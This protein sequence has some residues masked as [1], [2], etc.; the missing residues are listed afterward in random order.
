MGLNRKEQAQ[1]LKQWINAKLEKDRIAAVPDLFTEYFEENKNIVHE[2]YALSRHAFW[3]HFAEVSQSYWY[4]S[5]DYKGRLTAYYNDPT[6][7]K[8]S[9]KIRG[10]GGWESRKVGILKPCRSKDILVNSRGYDRQLPDITDV[11][12]ALASPKNHQQSTTLSSLE[13]SDMSPRRFFVPLQANDA[14]PIRGPDLDMAITSPPSARRRVHSGIPLSYRSP[15]AVELVRTAWSRAL[16]A[17]VSQE[18]AT[19]VE[20]LNEIHSLA[21]QTPQTPPLSTTQ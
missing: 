18:S 10:A 20:G 3:Q 15:R 16:Q 17:N 4:T 12:T 9:V 2:C 14:L 5:I 13:G 8:V 7:P 11:Q 19:S 6:Q 1:H 21:E